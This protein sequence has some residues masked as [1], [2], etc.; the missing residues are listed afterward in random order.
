MGGAAG[1]AAYTNATPTFRAAATTASTGRTHT[2][3]PGETPSLIARQYGVRLD[4]LM[5]A[6]PRL[7]PRRLRVGQA[8]S[9][10]AP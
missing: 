9:I 8:L 1:A 5:A 3:K 7:E 2:V 4:A 10:P 6:N